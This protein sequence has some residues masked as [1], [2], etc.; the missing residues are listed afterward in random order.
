MT[1]GAAPRMLV[2]FNCQGA[3]NLS[4]AAYRGLES[5]IIQWDV[6]TWAHGLRFWDERMGDLGGKL[7][8][9]LGSGNGGLSLFLALQ[10]CHVVCS[11]LKRPDARASQLHRRY[12][13]D[14]LIEYGCVDA[15]CIPHPDS[16]FDVVAL[17]SVLGALG[18]GEYPLEPQRRALAEI[19]R[20]LRPG[21]C[22][23]FAENMRG[24]SMHAWL[25]R[26]FTPWG[27]RWHYFSQA[28]LSELLSGFRSVDLCF[29]GFGATLGRREWQRTLLH[30]VDR[31]VV[32]LVPK[33]ARY[34]AFGVAV[35]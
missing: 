15:R 2:I 35:K 28:E 14:D 29:R 19:H 31:V 13:I 20:V 26:R 1:C 9:E 4:T 30:Q 34:V 11:D 10:G 33:S 24:T 18:T 5:E 22:F 8:L 12:G 32:P 17:K 3:S 25:R 27:S 6:A 16:S 7:G 23:L 21:G